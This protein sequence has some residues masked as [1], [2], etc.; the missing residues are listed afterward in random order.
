MDVRFRHTVKIDVLPSRT[1]DDVRELSKCCTPFEVYANLSNNDPLESDFT[2]HYV[3]SDN[4]AV[5][6]LVNINTGV[7]TTLSSVYG[8][9][10]FFP[11]TDTVASAFVVDW[12]LVLNLI[13]AGTYRFEA[14]YSIGGNAG[15]SIRGTF[16]LRNY[17]HRIVSSTVR[18]DCEFDDYYYKDNVHFRGSRFRDSM[19]FNGL[20]GKQQLGTEKREWVQN[21]RTNRDII[22]EDFNRYILESDPLTRCFTDRLFTFLFKATQINITDNG[23]FNHRI[24]YRDFPVRI[25][26]GETPEIEYQ[27][28]SEI[29]SF[30]LNMGD[31][32]DINL[33]RHNR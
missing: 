33:M 4:N 28:A 10:I 25:P 16:V 7:E 15:T 21:N 5:F 23:R 22:T 24:D 26:E 31:R 19:R 30:T 9:P 29:I 3:P 14:D 27:E 18:F 6:K 20:F 13:G 1:F 17:S 8:N 12:K 11:D 2:G 32:S